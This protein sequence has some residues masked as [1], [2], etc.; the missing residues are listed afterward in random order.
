MSEINEN[1]NLE[2][3]DPVTQNLDLEAEEAQDVPAIILNL[4]MQDGASVKSAEAWAVGQRG[5]VDVPSTDV[6]YH[7]N[8]KYYSE[9][10]AAAI[11]DIVVVQDAT[12]TAPKT[13]VWMPATAP[14]GVQVPTYAEHQAVEATLAKV[15]PTNTGTQGQIL[16]NNGQGGAVWTD[17]ATAEE[18]A[19][20]A[21]AWLNDH[22]SQGETLAIDNTLTL[23]G[24]AG[25]AKVTGDKISELKSA[26]MLIGTVGFNMASGG[27]H[28]ASNDRI[29]VSNI[30]KNDKYFIEIKTT[31]A[32]SVDMVLY[33]S[34]GGNTTKAISVTNGYYC[35]EITASRESGVQYVSLLI[36]D[37]KETAYSVTFSTFYSES[38]QN[39]VFNLPNSLFGFDRA[40][41]L[42]S[43]TNIN[44]LKTVGVYAIKNSDVSSLLPANA[45]PASYG[46]IMIVQ[47]NA[48][49]NTSVRQ[50]LYV[51]KN[52]IYT[53]SYESS[54]WTRWDR[55]ATNAEVTALSNAITEFYGYSSATEIGSS[56]DLDNLNSLSNVGVY[57]VKNSSMPTNYPANYGGIVVV[58]R[59][60]DIQ[61]RQIVFVNKH[62]I[63]TRSYESNTWTDWF[64]LATSADISTINES[65]AG[66]YGYP[67]ATEIGSST[68]LDN[69]NSLSDAGAYIV[70]NSSL[71]SNY[72]ATYGGLVIIQRNGNAQVRQLVYVNKG[73]L[74]TRCYD[75]SAWTDWERFLYSSDID[76]VYFGQYSKSINLN[77][78][79]NDYSI[80]GLYLCSNF[81]SQTLDNLPHD[82]SGVGFALH[83]IRTNATGTVFRQII[84]S[85]DSDDIYQRV[86]NGSTFSEW[87]RTE[88]TKDVDIDFVNA[89]E[90]EKDKS[91]IAF[92]VIADT[93]YG[94]TDAA[95]RKMMQVI[96]SMVGV[97]KYGLFDMSVHLG[98]VHQGSD[99]TK[100]VNCQDL[101]KIAKAFYK[102]RTFSTILRGNHDDGTWANTSSLDLITDSVW[103]NRCMSEYGKYNDFQ[104]NPDDP[105]GNY[106][107]RD[108]EKYKIRV[109]CLDTS[110]IP[111]ILDGGTLKYYQ[112]VYGMQETQ[113]K[114]LAE[115]ALII[116]KPDHAE[117]AIVFMSHV[118][119]TST[120][121]DNKGLNNYSV[122][123]EI[124]EA[125]MSGSSGTATSSTT[126]F[127][128]SVA[129]DFTSQGTGEIICDF[130]G[131]THEDSYD[132]T[133]DF[134]LIGF[135]NTF[136]GNG[137]FDVALINRSE[138]TIKTKRYNRTGFDRS[139]TYGT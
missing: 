112:H 35:E 51:N 83:I 26:L 115:K 108:F 97:S 57:I 73:T 121:G 17:A 37:T 32:I 114:W 1:L 109:I 6:T 116:D 31:P 18:V 39:K 103:R 25:D 74:Y 65:I 62:S 105:T 111:Y 20:A 30:N 117:W 19:T 79:L 40:V 36:N 104:Y 10:T 43:G 132:N 48:N 60:G 27:T 9:E 68:N 82:V 46:G 133:G 59:N 69:L 29:P 129:Y 91:A 49:A 70:K 34:G 72:P 54:T 41:T 100:A 8:A 5:G 66:F 124:A 87:S 94:K 95:S 22:V 92:G 15:T 38:T 90:S 77:S 81:V 84:T 78:D 122:F 106:F 45:Y 11:D 125:F 58:Q 4:D 130:H 2:V 52:S 126:D 44:D 67:T 99:H 24:Y 101:T 16:R 107:Y 47:R 28:S 64:R 102:Q 50:M 123:E 76:K 118:P 86:Y 113:L 71:P 131:H 128:A 110:D 21:E 13:K 96:E 7:N 12:P 53:R 98:D 135:L 134:P 139:W 56:T 23:S 136:A 33:E 89:V 3:T 88:T 137:Y 138:K 75:G 93:H 85:E 42:A 80:C 127:E 14:S 120:G 55:L 119:L 63:Y 61:V